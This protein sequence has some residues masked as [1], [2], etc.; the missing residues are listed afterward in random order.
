MDELEI[1]LV[2]DQD[3]F[4]TVLAIRREVFVEGQSVP[5]ERELDGLDD[6][7]EHIIV[8][9]GDEPIGCTRVRYDERGA[10]LERIAILKEWQGR[11]FGRRLV[12]FLVEHCQKQGMDEVVLHSQCAVRGFYEELGF[13]AHGP[14]FMDAGI[15]HVAMSLRTTD[16][17]H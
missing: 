2:K 8:L 6:T 5:L 10:R 7:A 3:E 9:L 1:R 13:T 16:I 14:I 17:D 4:D 15:E 12:G 11:G